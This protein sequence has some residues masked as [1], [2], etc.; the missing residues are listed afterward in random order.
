MQTY[1]NRV[2]AHPVHTRL[3]AV[4][5]Q[6]AALEP[7][8]R[9]DP[10]AADILSRLQQVNSHIQRA[11]ENV[12]PVLAPKSPLDQ[13][14][15]NLQQELGYLQNYQSSAAVAYLTNADSFADQALAQL[16]LLNVPA[17][18]ADIEGIRDAASTYRRTVAQLARNATAELQ[19]L[20]GTV[21]A[22]EA[23]VTTLDQT[24]ASQTARL[25]TAISSFQQQ[26]A[27]A[28]ANRLAQ[29]SDAEK[30]R[31]TVFEEAQ[32]KRRSEFTT[33]FEETDEQLRAY[34]AHTETNIRAHL[35]E[36]QTHAGAVMRTL[37][38]QKAM[39]QRLV[40]I[41]TDTGMVGGYQRVANEEAK[42]AK[43][44]E[45]VAV[46]TMVGLVAFA[47]WAFLPT[48]G[49]TFNWSAFAGRAFVTLSF[50]ALAAYAA[51]RAEHHRDEER[52][53]RRL[54]LELA[55]VGPFLDLLPEDVQHEVRRQLADR[56]F[57]QHAALLPQA[58]GNGSPTSAADVVQ[59]IA[60]EAFKQR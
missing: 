47:A 9:K 18:P 55:S 30:Q 28:E 17:Q 14:D 36:A 23:R 43:L 58:K 27:A 11:L 49:G 42:R 60:Q 29:F 3:R 8:A 56:F 52:R 34:L 41:I 37:D 57:G 31:A 32:E 40:G 39:A 53:N 20:S 38:E 19:E 16:A 48:L 5:S 24:I 54:E 21:A 26:S 59:V 51:R 1:V 46:V 22:I 45:V 44:W 4:E 33:A 25:D 12:D 15:A 35:A 50:G 13:V 10:E 7:Q 2:N 6:L